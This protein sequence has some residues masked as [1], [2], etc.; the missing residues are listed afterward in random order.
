MANL[1]ET[2]REE[3]IFTTFIRAIN[4]TEI[5][6]VLREPG[7]YTMFA[8]TDAAFAKMKSEQVVSLFEDYYNMSK[9]VKYH[10]APGIYRTTDLLDRL[11]LKT[12]E[13]QRLFIT[14]SATSELNTESFVDETETNGYVVK[15]IVTST[16]LES[17]KVNRA[18][19]TRGNVS[20]NNGLI[21]VIDKVL[22]P[23]FMIL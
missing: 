23:H 7:A 15:D 1:I 21:H 16:L 12:L 22:V 20:A 3:G 19:I 2:L 18:H 6:A 5:L 10:I 4:M 8:P 14:S 13:G 11:F 17:I 9:L